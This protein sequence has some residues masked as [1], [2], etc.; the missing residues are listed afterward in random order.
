MNH[1][2]KSHVVIPLVIPVVI[3]RD[4]SSAYGLPWSMRITLPKCVLH[5]SWVSMNL[6]W[7]GAS[8]TIMEPKNLG[9]GWAT[10]LKKI[11]V[12]QLG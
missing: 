7:I 4:L 8:G 2:E 1:H 5:R 6:H 11:R 10:P 9:G 12:R 3:T